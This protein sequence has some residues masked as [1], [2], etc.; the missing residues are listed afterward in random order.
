MPEY[1]IAKL[2]KEGNIKEYE[3][4]SKDE[5]LDMKNG[6]VQDLSAKEFSS[7]SEL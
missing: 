2:D 6:I 7:T 4:I 3:E 1:S 5:Y